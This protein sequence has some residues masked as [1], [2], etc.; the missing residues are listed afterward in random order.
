MLRRHGA[1]SA[2]VKAFYLHFFRSIRIKKKGAAPLS[3]WNNKYTFY[4]F[5]SYYIQHHF[6]GRFRQNEQCQ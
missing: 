5:T 3:G 2:M 4:I 6:A 1:I